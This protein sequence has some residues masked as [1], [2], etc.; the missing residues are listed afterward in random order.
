MKTDLYAYG[1]RPVYTRKQ[2]YICVQAHPCVQAHYEA[3]KKRPASLYPSLFIFYTAMCRSFFIYVHTSFF[4]FRPTCIYIH[5]QMYVCTCKYRPC[6]RRTKKKNQ[7]DPDLS[8]YY[9]ERPL[10]IHMKKSYT[11]MER[12]QYVYIQALREAD[13]KNK[14]TQTY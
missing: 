8:S 5:V 1:Q 6:V 13:K 3:D 7:A 10:Y 11:N 12:A 9:E 14:Q 4:V 2:T